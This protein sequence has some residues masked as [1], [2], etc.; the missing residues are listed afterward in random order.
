MARI[1]DLLRQQTERLDRLTEAQVQSVLAAYEEAVRQLEEELERLIRTGGDEATPW[2]AQRTRV[3][4]AQA[5]RAM[6]DLQSR[7]GA[8]LDA[9]TRQH[10]EQSAADLAAIIRQ[11]EP[12]FL[13]TGQMP[14]VEAIARLTEPSGLALHRH[15][16]ERY[17][18]DV[19]DQVQRRLSVALAKGESRRDATR[20]I[21]AVLQGN[22]SRA[23]LIV[24]MET[25]RAYNESHLRGVQGWAANDPPGTPN[26]AMKRIVEMRDGRT[27]RSHPASAVADDLTA[28]P[29]EEFRLPAAE[30]LAEYRRRFPKRKR[31]R[32]SGMVWE[33]RGD[34]YYGQHNPIH[35][36]DRGRIVPWRESWGKGRRAGSGASDASQGQRAGDRVAP[37][38]AG[39]APGPGDPRRGR[40]D[41][42][43]VRDDFTGPTLPSRRPDPTARAR[44]E[45]EPRKR[46]GGPEERAN[47]DA[48]VW[49]AHE[50]AKRGW[51][52]EFTPRVEGTPRQDN[53]IEGRKFEFWRPQEA[54]FERFRHTLRRKMRR[55]ARR[56]VIQEREGGLKLETAAEHVRTAT[57]ADAHPTRERVRGLK[58]VW[59]QRLNGDIDVLYVAPDE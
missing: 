51:D 11:Q 57:S 43:L 35:Y 42:G 13:L 7:L 39:G 25:G 18:R 19:I 56:M 8:E 16:L 40:D 10:R 1:D 58:E 54:S 55:Q 5:E 37:L 53:L 26:P 36:N 59:Y 50:I 31:L 27:R 46:A 3:A 17:S 45:P 23:A 2:T 24:R 29:D 48:A 12:E 49:G 9:A 4:L 21:T 34:A 44:G 32:I 41:D 6:A 30:I 47:W 22:R 15:S 52:V 14:H 38:L 20:A 28:R 33:R